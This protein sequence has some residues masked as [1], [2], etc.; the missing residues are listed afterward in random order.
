[1]D[2]IKII[3]NMTGGVIQGVST[4]TN[5]SMDILI[6]DYNPED[7]NKEAVVDI[8]QSDG[9]N[10]KALIQRSFGPVLEPVWVNKV[11]KLLNK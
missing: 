4:N 7:Y 2:E 6:V 10:S 11:F 8:P 1:M 9:N 5:Q 3:I